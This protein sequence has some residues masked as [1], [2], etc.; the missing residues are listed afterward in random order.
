MIVISLDD[1]LMWIQACEQHVV[2]FRR[3]MFMDMENL[4][5]VQ[6]QDTLQ[7]ATICGGGY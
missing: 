5:I 1:P 2:L 4:V 6:H 7:Y 3:V